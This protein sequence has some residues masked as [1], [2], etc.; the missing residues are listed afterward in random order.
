MKT[1]KRS[2]ARV[3]WAL[4]G[5]MAVALTGC[6]TYVVEPPPRE[7]Y[8]PPQVQ[9]PPPVV[10][11]EPPSQPPVVVIRTEN[12]F[13]EPLG[14]YGQWVVVAGYG[15]CWRPARVETGWRPYA[16]GYWQ[17]TDAG[18]YWVSDEPWAWA[19]Y[20]YGRW[21]FQAQF[22]W[23]WVPQTQWA[24]AWVA[25][26]EG[27]GYV[28][29][30]PLRPSARIGVSIGAEVHE[31]AYASRAFVFVEHRRMLEPVR[32]TTVIV[33]NTTIINQTVNIT[34]V[35]VVNKTVINEGPRVEVIE[36]ESGRKIQAVPVR[37]FRRR[38]EAT[39]AGRQRNLPTA[40]G[41]QVQSPVRTTPPPTQAV[42][43]R[44]AQVVAPPA[45]PVTPPPRPGVEKPA[46]DEKKRDLGA[47]RKA[48]TPPPVSAPKPE[49]KRETNPSAK[50]Q[51]AP[52]V[53]KRVGNPHMSPKEKA[54]AAEK[55]KLMKKQK[56]E[57]EQKQKNEVQETPPS[58]GPAHQPQ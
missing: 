49:V 21:D 45:A 9:Q 40:P 32:P 55:N 19:T 36:R 43:P 10:Y 28:G 51:T 39:V 6:Q 5:A 29:W 24:P 16:N 47:E 7:V 22:G 35:T 13:Y 37:E 41:K 34:K 8:V 26:R 12:D 14:A 31:S 27:G 57:R 11:V 33:N 46:R 30:A 25:W 2:A 54:R 18:W 44:N 42:Q 15:R 50:I 53:E 17:R 23:I 58:T 48:A 1:T 4:C 3:G 52:P 20:H 56:P 38:E